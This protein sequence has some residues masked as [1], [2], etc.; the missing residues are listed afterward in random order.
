[1]KGKIYT[2]SIG[3][4][5]TEQD[6]VEE[7]LDDH[8]I[9]MVPYCVPYPCEPPEYTTKHGSFGHVFSAQKEKPLKRLRH[10]KDLRA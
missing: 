4:T 2:T 1:M 5:W 8:N 7:K 9:V 6:L 10:Y 3:T